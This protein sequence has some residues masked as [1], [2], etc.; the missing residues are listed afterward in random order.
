MKLN[1][2]LGKKKAGSLYSTDNRGVVFAYDKD[3]LLSADSVKLSLSLPL[4]AEEFSQKQCIPFFSGLLP[5]EDT[6]KKIAD[7]LH[8]SDT[9]TLKLLEALGGE[10]AGMISILSEDSTCDFT[11]SFQ[12]NEENYEELSEE[13]LCEFIKMMPERPLIKADDKLRLSLAGSQE[14]LALAKI[15]GKWYLPLNGAPSTHILKPAKYGNLSSIAQNEYI[16]MTLAKELGLK[17]PDVDLLNF[18]GKDI[19]VV[20]RYDRHIEGNMIQRLHQ[21]DFCQA[22]GILSTEKYQS[23]GGPG[24]SSI[25]NCIKENLTVPA[26]ELKKFLTYVIFNYLVGNCD[27]HGKNYS[28]LYCKNTT[29]LSPMYDIVATTIYPFLTDK[30]SMKIGSHYEIDK[31][32]KEDFA[33]LAKEL[34]IKLSVIQGIFKDFSSK[35][36]AA[37]KKL[38][39]NPKIDLFLLEKIFDE[40]RKRLFTLHAKC[41]TLP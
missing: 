14:K 16:C 18:A 19:F 3:Y 5:E 30:L 4:Q 28:I 36:D 27:S 1:V 22:L 40:V 20:E 12:L 9:S 10:C 33:Q 11:E 13:R 32:C 7:Y 38:K 35:L 8:I 34:N 21:E 37:F 25:Y 26:L 41:D 23:D 15:E 24:I 2:F 39:E 29:R 31:V 17:V 6:R